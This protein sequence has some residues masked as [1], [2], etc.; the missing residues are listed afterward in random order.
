M[1]RYNDNQNSRSIKGNMNRHIDTCFNNE[2]NAYMHKKGSRCLHNIDEIRR[3][4]NIDDEMNK[5]IEGKMNSNANMNECL[6]RKMNGLL[7]DEM[8]DGGRKLKV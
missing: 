8:Q 5:H 1:H 7:C 2:V 3:Y 4:R 6:N